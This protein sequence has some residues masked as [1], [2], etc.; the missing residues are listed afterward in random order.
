MIG[1]TISHYRILEKLGEG[2]MG[3]VYKAVDTK[4]ERE[5]MSNGL[6]VFLSI[7]LLATPVAAQN[8]VTANPTRPSA[9]DNAYLTAPGYIE[10]EI[11]GAVMDKFWSIPTFSKFAVHKQVELGFIMS[12]LINHTRLNGNSDTE[13]G[14]AGFQAKAQLTEQDWGAVAV[15]GRIDFPSGV[16]P[17]YTLYSVVS[18]QASG[19]QLDLTLGGV[20]FE[21]G[22]GDYNASFQ[23]AAAMSPKLTGKLGGFVEIFGEASSEFNPVAVDFGVSLSQSPR[24]VPDASLTIGLNDDAPDWQIQFGLTTVLFK[25]L[26]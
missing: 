19:F 17:K 5:V 26:N 7:V 8:D 21:P 15:V 14:D 6:F 24:F 12:G 1:K 25:V 18:Y 13:V 20:L 16:D 9:A 4:L 2:G 23:Y 10:L 3:V 11:G 22:D